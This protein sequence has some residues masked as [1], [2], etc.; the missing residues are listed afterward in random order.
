MPLCVCV[1]FISTM[2]LTFLVALMAKNLSAMQKTQVRSLCWEDSLEKKMAT[3]SSI[4]AW[5]IP[6]T[7]EPGGLW[8]LES[9]KNQND[10]V[11]KRT[12]TRE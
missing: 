6:W 4:L 12:T 2:K 7:D 11:I 3:H 5:E 1:T 8:S 9:Q 10:L